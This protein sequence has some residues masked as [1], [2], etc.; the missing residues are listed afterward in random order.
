MGR[1]LVIR[2]QNLVGGHQWCDYNFG[3]V[4]LVM[5]DLSFVPDIPSGPLDVYRNS[6]SFDWKRLKLA[7][8]GDLSLLKLKVF[9]P[10]LLLLRFITYLI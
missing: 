8:E 7:L 10:D 2:W 6:A 1:G 9:I 5:E 3:V 4:V